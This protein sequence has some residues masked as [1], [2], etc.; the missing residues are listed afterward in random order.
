MREFLSCSSE[1]LTIQ[2]GIAAAEDSKPG[3]AHFILLSHIAHIEELLVVED[4]ELSLTVDVGGGEN[5]REG[6]PDE[7]FDH[8]HASHASD[9]PEGK[10]VGCRS[11]I[12]IIAIL[13]FSY[14]HPVLLDRRLVVVHTAVKHKFGEEAHAEVD[15]CLMLGRYPPVILVEIVEVIRGLSVGFRPNNI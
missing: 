12:H 15:G 1:V 7:F 11:H 14:I 2:E 4:E 13:S 10:S 8:H 6:P 9:Q 5:W 3:E